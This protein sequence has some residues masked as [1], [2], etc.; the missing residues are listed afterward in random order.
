MQTIHNQLKK[1]KMKKINSVVIVMIILSSCTFLFAQNNVKMLEIKYFDFSMTT[2]MK[3]ECSEFEKA[4][5][6]KTVQIK[7]SAIIATFLSLTKNLK[8]DTIDKYTPDAR[9]KI[10]LLYNDGTKDVICVSNFG[11]CCNNIPML[12]DEKYVT[13]IKKIIKPR[14]GEFNYLSH[15]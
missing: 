3:I 2:D 4:C 15:S 8:K 6:Y 9:A 1:R 5:D 12:Y 10:T 13:Y 11:I 14:A 7:D